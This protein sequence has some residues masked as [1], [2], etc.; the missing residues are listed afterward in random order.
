MYLYR[1]P[2]YY[3]GTA[4][5]KLRAPFLLL[6]TRASD[7]DMRPQLYAVIRQ[8]ALKQLGHWMM[9]NANIKGHWMTISGDYGND[10]LPMTLDDDEFPEDAVPLPDDLCHAFWTG[11]GHNCAGCEAPLIRDWALDHLPKIRAA[12]RRDSPFSND[13][14]WA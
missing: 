7:R 12:E 5:V 8:V 10:G 1:T 3:R 11:G 6:M 9:G 4:Q 2:T 14:R 13:R